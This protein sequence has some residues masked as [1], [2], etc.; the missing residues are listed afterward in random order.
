VRVSP[1]K[2]KIR[3]PKSKAGDAAAY[4]KMK[5]SELKALIKS[6]GLNVGSGSGKGGRV[7]KSDLIATL[8]NANA[9][10]RSPSRSPVR[11]SPSPVR[12]VSPVVKDIKKMKLAELKAEA[13]RL[14]LNVVGTGK[15]GRKKKSDYI[16]A[17]ANA[18]VSPVRERTI[19]PIRS[20]VRS[21]ARVPTPVRS[22]VRLPSDINSQVLDDFERMMKADEVISPVRSPIRVPTPVRRE[23]P[24]RPGPSNVKIPESRITKVKG[25]SDDCGDDC[26]EGKYCYA[27]AKKAICKDKPMTR[28]K[29]VYTRPGYAPMYGAEG[30]LKKIKEKFDKLDVNGTITAVGSGERAK[31]KAKTPS[32]VRVPTPVRTPSPV[33]SPIR[34][35]PVRRAGKESVIDD[36]VEEILPPPPPPTNTGGGSGLTS[37]EIADAFR[38]CLRSME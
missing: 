14:N 27:T 7:L 23:S 18:R 25:W 1:P 17:L 9:G 13:G 21:P 5:V 8:S 11:P 29:Y 33:R 16:A 34:D 15:G 22:P 19:S 6:R 10:S 32:P 2:T 26:G 31:A 36:V 3:V 35:S 12:R 30:T 4:K 38:D 28:S 24:V 20:P 37:T